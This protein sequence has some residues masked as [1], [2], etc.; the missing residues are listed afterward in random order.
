MHSP[1]AGP[2]R[3]PTLLPSRHAA[4][5]CRTSL[6]VG[7][8]SN[9]LRNGTRPACTDSHG[10]LE[11]AGEEGAGAPGRLGGPSTCQGPDRGGVPRAGSRDAGSGH[12]PSPVGT[13]GQRTE[14]SAT[15]PARGPA[16]MFPPLRQIGRAHV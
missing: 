7:S 8:G 15:I 14:L 10:T 16:W 3:P 5:V 1:F 13:A 2:D 9:A 6:S 12:G 4:H 11:S